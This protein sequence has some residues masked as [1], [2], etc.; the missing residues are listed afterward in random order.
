MKIDDVILTLASLLAGAVASAV[1]S[2]FVGLVLGRIFP[3]PVREGDVARDGR[4]RVVVRQE[5]FRST[6]RGTQMCTLELGATNYGDHA[7]PAH[8]SAVLFVGNQSFP[9][10]EFAG[11]CFRDPILPGYA[12]RGLIEF[13]IPPHAV[14][15]RVEVD[16]DG[17][18]ASVVI[19][20][21]PPKSPP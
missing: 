5:G 20:L 8:R 3:A 21:D 14:P 19:E 17:D 2:H 18:G 12:E 9:A 11:S 6:S 7:V 1:I 4:F 16:V 15:D 13:E 10:R